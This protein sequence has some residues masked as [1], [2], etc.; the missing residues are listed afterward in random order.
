MAETRIKEL[1]SRYKVP[2]FMLI[3]A[4][5]I[6]LFPTKSTDKVHTEDADLYFQQMLSSTQGVG[7]AMIAISENG[8][9]VTCD[10]ATNA[11]VRLDIIHAVSSYTGFSSDKITILKMEK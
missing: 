5:T 3:L 8:V 4:G 1:L 10:G 7:R 9:V 11:K 6:L 2:V